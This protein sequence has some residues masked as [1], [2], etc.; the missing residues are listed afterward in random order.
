MIIKSRRLGTGLLL[1]IKTFVFKTEKQR[2]SRNLKRKIADVF[3]D[4]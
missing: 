4:D 1:K 2:P 3:D